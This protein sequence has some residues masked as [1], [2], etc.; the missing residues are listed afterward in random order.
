MTEGTP[1]AEP[2]S[3]PLVEGMAPLWVDEAAESAFRAEA[4]DRGEAV[5]ANAPAPDE[6][7]PAEA[8]ALPALDELVQRLP[9]DVREVLEDLFRARFVA[10]KRIPRKALKA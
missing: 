1:A 2:E 9:V 6:P 3:V 10:V 5:V 7:E 4:R 8:G